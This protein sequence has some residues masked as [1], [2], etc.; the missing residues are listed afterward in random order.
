MPYRPLDPRAM[1]HFDVFD[2]RSYRHPSAG[3][4]LGSGQP[5]PWHRYKGD[6]GITSV[7]FGGLKKLFRKKPKLLTAGTQVGTPPILPAGGTPGLLGT[8]IDLVR[9]HPVAAGGVVGAVGAIPGA[10]YGYRKLRGAVA[11]PGYAPRRRGRGITSRE[12]R[13][14]RKVVRLLH[15]VGMQPRGLRRTPRHAFGRA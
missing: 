3:Y 8:I 7:I 12:L 4:T 14:F 10:I 11:P 13:G 1:G 6:P 15:S 2:Y 9:Q 5:W